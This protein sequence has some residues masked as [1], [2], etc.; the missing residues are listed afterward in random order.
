MDSME[1]IKS[2]GEISRLGF[3]GPEGGFHAVGVLGVTQITVEAVPGQ[4]SNVP[5]FAVWK[6]AKC[7]S[8]WNGAVVECVQYKQEP[9]TADPDTEEEDSLG[10]DDIPIP[11]ATPALDIGSQYP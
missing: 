10:P 7:D 4:M 5:W 11:T 6:G 1:V 9:E 3:S 8:I 2:K